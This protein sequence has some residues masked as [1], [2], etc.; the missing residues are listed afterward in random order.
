MSYARK[1]DGEVCP[2]PFIASVDEVEAELREKIEDVQRKIDETIELYEE[3]RGES[4]DLD[5]DDGEETVNVEIPAAGRTNREHGVSETIE[6]PTDRSNGGAYTE[7]VPLQGGDVE[8]PDTITVERPV[9]DGLDQLAEWREKVHAMQV[10][11]E[12]ERVERERRQRDRMNASPYYVDD[13]EAEGSDIPAAGT[14][15]WGDE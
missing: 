1:R 7:E 2:P 13:S 10:E 14:K 8:D 5:G 4:F 6:V 3:V 12:E 9:H 15:E 11:S